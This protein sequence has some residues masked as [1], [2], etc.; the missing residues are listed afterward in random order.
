MVN[1]GKYTIHG[2]YGC[3]GRFFQLTF[4][5]SLLAHERQMSEDVVVGL[6]VYWWWLTAKIPDEQ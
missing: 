5:A 4:Q 2:S 3:G 1:V 6:L